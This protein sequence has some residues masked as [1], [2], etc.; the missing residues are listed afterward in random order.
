[1][2]AVLAWTNGTIDLDLY[3]TNAACDTYPPLHCTTLATSEAATGTSE[4]VSRSVS[5]GEQYK[6]WVDD[7]S[8]TLPSDYTIQLT[9]Q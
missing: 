3:L 2:K 9:I 7:F 1:M 5:A 6:L 8:T 4:T